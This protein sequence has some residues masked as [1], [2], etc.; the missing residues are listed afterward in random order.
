MES[1]ENRHSYERCK[2]RANAGMK[3]KLSQHKGQR[4]I[5]MK[6]VCSAVDQLVECG[7]RLH[8]CLTTSQVINQYFF[9]KIRNQ[10]V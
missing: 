6:S 9:C 5:L 7:R 8:Q 10:Q 2:E 4:Q 1:W 3:L